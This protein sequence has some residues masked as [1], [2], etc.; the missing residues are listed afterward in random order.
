[1]NWVCAYSFSTLEAK[2]E[3]LTWSPQCR[4]SEMLLVRQKLSS[5]GIFFLVWLTQSVSIRHSHKTIASCTHE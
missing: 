1:M 3:D 4:F 5:P 2:G